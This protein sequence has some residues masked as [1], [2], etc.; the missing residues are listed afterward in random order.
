MTMHV[1][2]SIRMLKDRAGMAS[3]KALFQTELVDQPGDGHFTYSKL[4]H[5]FRLS[6]FPMVVCDEPDA[7]I[8]LLKGY[9]GH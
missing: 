3:I 8:S 2:N 5:H 9:L 1:K 4:L 7:F 6:H